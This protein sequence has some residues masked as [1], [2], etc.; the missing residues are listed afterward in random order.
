MEHRTHANR[1]LNAHAPKPQQKRGWRE[2]NRSLQ[3]KKGIGT[4]HQQTEKE[5]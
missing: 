2:H 3:P 5:K 4:N 1:R